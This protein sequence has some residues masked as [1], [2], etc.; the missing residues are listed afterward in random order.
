MGRS[1]RRALKPRETAAD[2]AGMSK[3]SCP[4]EICPS[5][6]SDPAFGRNHL[7][8]ME[9]EHAATLMGHDAL[10]ARAEGELAAAL[11]SIPHDR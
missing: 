10:I 3:R 6:A 8:E 5:R 2:A 11:R 1:R 7:D 4:D 9:T